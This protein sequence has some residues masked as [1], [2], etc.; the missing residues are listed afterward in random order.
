[1]QA[2]MSMQRLVAALLG[3]AFIEWAVWAWRPGGFW[4][5]IAG[6]TALLGLLALWLR[7]GWLKDPGPRQGDFGVGLLAAVAL[8]A[9]AWLG[10]L[11]LLHVWPAGVLEL[12]GLY[13]L[14]GT[15]PWPLVAILVALV[16]APGEE[17]FWRGL[18]LVGLRERLGGR[19]WLAVFGAALLFG[20][21]HLF[22][23][24]PVLALAA[25]AGGLAWGAL[26][27]RTGR[28][29]PVI[30]SHILW[31]LAVLLFFPLR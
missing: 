20:A 26:Y 9:V 22:S 6:G 19:P 28:L 25:M 11:A 4:P 23:G 3:A 7:R 10:H 21:A 15:A 30:V 27:Q 16:I 24:S 17:L 2:E 8:Y 1:M 31:D 12:L 5:L 18:V 14:V 29:A 13:G